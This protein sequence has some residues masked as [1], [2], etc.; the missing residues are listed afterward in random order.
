MTAE[1]R[2]AAGKPVQKIIEISMT[3]EEAEEEG[4]VCGGTM[5]VLIEGVLP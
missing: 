1:A 5:K 2:K 4:M 3:G